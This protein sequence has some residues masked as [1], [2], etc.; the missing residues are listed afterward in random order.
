M[1]AANGATGSHDFVSDPFAGERVELMVRVSDGIEGPILYF[2][3]RIWEDIMRGG[4]G[5]RRYLEREEKA[6]LTR[7]FHTS[8]L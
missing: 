4:K 7:A 5:G 6:L 3:R 8:R 1:S 2:S